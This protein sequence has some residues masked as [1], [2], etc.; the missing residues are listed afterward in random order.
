MQHHLLVFL[1]KVFDSNL[2]MEKESDKCKKNWP[3]LSKNVIFVKDF[4]KWESGREEE[5]GQMLR[6]GES[7]WKVYEYS[8]SIVLFL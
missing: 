2:I 5:S 3:G 6:I 4:L 7:R 8:S 1:P